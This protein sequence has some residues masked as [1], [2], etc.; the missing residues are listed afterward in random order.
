MNIVSEI[1]LDIEG[2]LTSVGADLI[3][4]GFVITVVSITIERRYRNKMC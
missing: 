3:P 4:S 1:H 2:I